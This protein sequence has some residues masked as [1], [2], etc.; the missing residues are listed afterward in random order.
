MRSAD[1]KPQSNATVLSG[2]AVLSRRE[3]FAAE[4]DRLSGAPTDTHFARRVA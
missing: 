3:A 2:I 4:F 1:A